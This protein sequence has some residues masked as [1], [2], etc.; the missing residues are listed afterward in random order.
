MVI[1]V[2]T[3]VLV[4]ACNKN[5]SQSST[6]SAQASLDPGALNCLSGSELESVQP[7]LPQLEKETGVKL[8]MTSS[9]TL[10]SVE[11]L[12]KGGSAGYDCGWFS[13]NKYLMLDPAVRGLVKAS[14]PIMISPVILGVKADKA[15]ALGWKADTTTWADVAKAASANQFTFAM[16]SPASSNTGMSAL[17]GVTAALSGTTAAIDE[18]AIEKVAL[19][20][21]G[22][23]QTIFSDSSGWLTTAYVAQMNKPGSVDGIINYESELIRLNREQNANLTLIYPKEGIVTADYPIMLFNSAKKA[24]FDKVTAFFKRDD[25]Q[26]QLMQTTYRRPVSANV[27]A[28]PAMFG[29]HLLVDVAF[30][31]KMDTIDILLESY[32]NKQ[33]RPA[34]VYFVLDTSGS[35][36]NNGG[37]EQLKVALAGLAGADQSLTG[38]FARLREREKISVLEFA[39]TIKNRH[40]YRIGTDVKEKAGNFAEFT[41]DAQAMEPNGGTAIF[42]SVQEAYDMAVKNQATEPGYIQS[43]VL[44]TDGI[45]NEGISGDAFVQRYQSRPAAEKNIR[46]FGILFGSDASKD[47]IQMLADLTGGSVFDGSKSISSVFKKIRGYQ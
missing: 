47:Q 3:L 26:K 43:I 9:G 22:H 36:G 10:A 12:S 42:S 17:I 46:I 30:P 4:A 23:G 11:T 18:K 35:M 1:A 44:M 25:I 29:E 13:H 37:I 33:R 45:S 40:D 31:A 8:T 16:T 39:S 41:R 27:A 2:C 5:T 38:R 15:K 14:E 32:L 24:Q 28:D 34:H 6:A 19:S 21:F 20:G 7:L